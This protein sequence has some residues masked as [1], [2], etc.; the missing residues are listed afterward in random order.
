MD[1]SH[2]VFVVYDPPKAG[3]PYL[4]AIFFPGKDDPMVA[5]FPTA[6]AAEQFNKNAAVHLATKT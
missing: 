4:S 6:A 5:A 2:V 1:Q 3:F